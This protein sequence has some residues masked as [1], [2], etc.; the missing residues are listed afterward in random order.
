MYK[1][2]KV[3]RK[4]KKTSLIIH[5]ISDLYMSNKTT[6]PFYISN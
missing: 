3:E 5:M 4:E 1:I 6:I 2:K